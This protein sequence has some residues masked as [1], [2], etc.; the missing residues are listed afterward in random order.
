MLMNNKFLYAKVNINIII[1]RLTQIN[2]NI[3]IIKIKFWKIYKIK[4]KF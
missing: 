3:L 4:K 1:K 2:N